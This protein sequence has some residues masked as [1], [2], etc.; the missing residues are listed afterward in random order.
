MKQRR[1]AERGVA[2]FLL[3]SGLW[4]GDVIDFESS[5]SLHKFLF[6]DVCSLKYSRI[7]FVVCFLLFGD[8]YGN[9]FIPYF[10]V[11]FIDHATK[12]LHFDF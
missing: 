10:T 5:C 7:M 9:S 1:T 3:C 11:F 12:R 8:I 2:L 4:T 6:A